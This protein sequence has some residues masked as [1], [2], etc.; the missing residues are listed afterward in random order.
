M[1]KI[2]LGILAGFLLAIWGMTNADCLRRLADWIEALDDARNIELVTTA[3][4]VFDARGKVAG[5]A[6]D[7]DAGA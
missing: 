2:A 6:A 5:G 7:H 3:L 1:S 4:E